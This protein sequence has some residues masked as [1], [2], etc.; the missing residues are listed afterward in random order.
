MLTR[1]RLVPRQPRAIKR[2]TPTALHPEG[3]YNVK[4]IHWN[5][6]TMP[7]ALRCEN[8]HQI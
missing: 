7:T 4:Y 2:T 3:I 1:G 5:T 8:I 6:D